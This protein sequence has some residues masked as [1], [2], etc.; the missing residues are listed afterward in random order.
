MHL[1]ASPPKSGQSLFPVVVM[2]SEHKPE[3][4]EPMEHSWLRSAT[5]KKYQP[6]RQV[7]IL[8]DCH[9]PGHRQGAIVLHPFSTHADQWMGCH[10]CPA[11]SRRASVDFFV[12][13]FQAYHSPPWS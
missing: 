13:V 3:T 7:H 11:P 2:A 8:C 10:L 12:A 6:W 5:L 4:V 1:C 9:V